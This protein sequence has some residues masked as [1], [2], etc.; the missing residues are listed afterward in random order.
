MNYN[1]LI[2]KKLLINPS[3]EICE[4]SYLIMMEKSLTKKNGNI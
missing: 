4:F 2:K 3:L 1:V